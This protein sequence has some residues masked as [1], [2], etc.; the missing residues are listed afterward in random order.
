MKLWAIVFFLLPLLGCIYLGW[1]VWRILPLAT[2][3]KVLVLA[4]MLAC[5]LMLFV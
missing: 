2:V 5:I 1:S 3:W 4:I